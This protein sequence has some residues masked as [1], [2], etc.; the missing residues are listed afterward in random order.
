MPADQTPIRR[1]LYNAA[2]AGVEKSFEYVASNPAAR[3]YD[4]ASVSSVTSGHAFHHQCTTDEELQESIRLAFEENVVALWKRAFGPGKDVPTEPTEESK[5]SS[6]PA[7]AAE[8]PSKSCEDAFQM[9]PERTEESQMS[10]ET[11]VTSEV[12]IRES[13]LLS[14]LAEN[15]TC[16]KQVLN[17]PASDHF[18]TSDILCFLFLIFII[19]FYW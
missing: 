3:A 18:R 8:M 4:T 13:R 7:K 2:L 14:H 15:P 6:E 5:I 16:I 11:V 19:I 17:S 1:A 12:P 10:P 9:C